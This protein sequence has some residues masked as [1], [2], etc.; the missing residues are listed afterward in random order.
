MV[1][2]Q[3]RSPVVVRNVE[4]AV[5]YFDQAGRQV[6]EVQRYNF[7]KA[8]KPGEEG[9]VT[10]NLTDGRGLRSSVSRAIIVK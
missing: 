5:A 1:G 7:R 3:N 6:S 8:L 4:V 10:T 2:L 9:T